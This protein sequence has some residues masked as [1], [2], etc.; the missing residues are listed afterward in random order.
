VERNPKA[1]QN[2][3]KI[4]APTEEEEQEE[5]GERNVL[6]TLKKIEK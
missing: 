1:G 6:I 5:E 4:V 3:Q 2:P